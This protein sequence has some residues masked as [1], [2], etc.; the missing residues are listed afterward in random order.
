MTKNEP[1][2][3]PNNVSRIASGMAIIK[4][5]I[6]ASHEVRFDGNFDGNIYSKS[7]IIIG[8]QAHLSGSITCV[9]LDVWGSFEGSITAKDTVTVKPG[10]SIKGSVHSSKLVVELG[11]RL[12]GE[13][14]MITEDEFLKAC[15]E[16]EFLKNGVNPSA[17]QPEKPLE[18]K[19]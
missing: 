3:N 8:E 12:D 13:S 2:A 10:A 9:N 19:K 18:N 5:E 1:T 7:R 4:G 15:N 14:K 16:N 11:S 6:N 17:P